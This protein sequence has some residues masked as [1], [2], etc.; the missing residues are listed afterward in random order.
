MRPPRSIAFGHIASQ[1]AKSAP[2][3]VDRWLPG[4]RR[5]GR[6]WVVRNPRRSDGKAG[7]FKVNLST[8]RWSDFATGDRGGDLIALAAYLFDLKQ[9]EAAERVAEMLGVDLYE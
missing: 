9:N 3:I 6:E 1:A 5:E 4:G 8:G 7:S 2:T